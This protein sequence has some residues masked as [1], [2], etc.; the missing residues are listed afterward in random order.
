MSTEIIKQNPFQS[1]IDRFN[2]A[3]DILNLDEPICQKLQRP[4]KQIVVNFSI[5]LDNGNEQNFEGYRVIHNTAL[6][7]SKGG[8]R[9]DNAVN[10]EEVKALAA[11][12]TWK[13]AVTGIPFGGAK[14]GIIC[15]PNTLSKRELEKIT[16]AYTKSLADIFGPDKDVPA[17][18]MGT[19]P[20]EMGWLMDEF[21]LVH[22]K[23]I[24]GVVTGKH[25]HSGGSLGRVEAT[26]RGVSI[27]TLLA[28]KKLK[29]KPALSSVAVQ[30]FG[31]VGLHSALF[32][33]E[34]GLKVLAVSDISEAL[35]SPEGI[36]IPELILYYN[37]NGKSI[38]GY[39]N[40]I[41]IKHEEL[42]LLEVDVLIPAAKEDVITKLNANDVRTKIIVEG[43]NGPVSSDADEILQENKVLVIPDILANAGGVTVSY[44]E[45]VQNTLVET[46]GVNQVN[47][48]LESILEKSFNTVFKTA[49][50][51]KV[52]PRIASYILALE[53]VAERQAVKEVLVTGTNFQH[54]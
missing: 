48:Q 52:S 8:I 43:A 28:L 20:D 24:H 4:E 41:S 12:M 16:R 29:L 17:P 9:Y 25:L 33:Y 31:N 42:L 3:A 15:D 21:S 45:W 27:I 50:K 10:L 47:K 36:N 11:W 26:G 51:Y 37:L 2:I 1:M 23:T 5:V 39:P 38:K 46:W 53:K 18:D 19:G 49:N 35:Y 30:G 54:N 6:G 14:G 7:P 32:L 22:G 44:F 13:S 34:K 40:S